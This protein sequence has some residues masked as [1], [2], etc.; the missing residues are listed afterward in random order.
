MIEDALRGYAVRPGGPLHPRTV[1]TLDFD[2]L[3]RLPTEWT[4]DGFRR[5]QGDQAWR[6]RFRWAQ[7]WAALGGCLLILAE[8]Q[9]RPD[10]DVALRMAAMRWV[11]SES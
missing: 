4:G 1:A 11:C 5:R 9:S 2:T 7:D 6:L 3:E 8:F 10:L